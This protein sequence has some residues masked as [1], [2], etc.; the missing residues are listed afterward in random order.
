MNSARL[1]TWTMPKGVAHTN[2]YLCNS[3]WQKKI[4]SGLILSWERLENGPQTFE[5]RGSVW[6]LKTKLRT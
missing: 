6:I 5:E 2:D 1:H 3:H 4:T